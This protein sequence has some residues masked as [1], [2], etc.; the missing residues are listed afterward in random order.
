MNKSESIYEDLFNIS[1]NEITDI[2]NYVSPPKPP[3]TIEKIQ[4][5]IKLKHN[6]ARNKRTIKNL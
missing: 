1:Q 2:L 3:L 4:K 5:H 6:I